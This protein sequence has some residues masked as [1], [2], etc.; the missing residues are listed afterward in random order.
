[1]F[2]PQATRPPHVLTGEGLP[3]EEFSEFGGKVTEM[4][5]LQGFAERSDRKPK[6]IAIDDLDSRGWRAGVGP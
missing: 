2:L 3:N 6:L 5:N 4:L 1:M